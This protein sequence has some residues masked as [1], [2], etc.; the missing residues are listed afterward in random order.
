VASNFDGKAHGPRGVL[1]GIVRNIS[2]GGLYFATRDLIPV[3]STAD[4][5]LAVD[6]KTLRLTCEV[7]HHQKIDNQSGMGVK[8]LRLEPSSL[9]VIQKYVDAHAAEIIPVT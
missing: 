9:S 6:G 7:R 1:R 2:V 5:E 4:F 3:G 8:F